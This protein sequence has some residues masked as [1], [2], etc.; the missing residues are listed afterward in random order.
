MNNTDTNT[1]GKHRSTLKSNP[2]A[3][4]GTI[5]GDMLRIMQLVEDNKKLRGK[6]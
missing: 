2:R 4:E 5:V 1:R 6:R 3:S